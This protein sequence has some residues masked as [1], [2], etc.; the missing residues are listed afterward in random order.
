MLICL[1]DVQIHRDKLGIEA[2]TPCPG[3]RW[4]VNMYIHTFSIHLFLISIPI[5]CLIFVFRS[6]GPV[7]FRLYGSRYFKDS[8]TAFSSLDYLPSSQAYLFTRCG[9]EA[10]SVSTPLPSLK[11]RYIVD[12]TT[13]D[14]VPICDLQVRGMVSANT[15]GSRKLRTGAQSPQRFKL[16]LI[17]A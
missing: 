7:H 3:S 14:L 9:D 5:Y 12:D 16:F 11:H 10:E 2:S 1:L 6:L 8:G 4:I 15:I 13:E 17:V